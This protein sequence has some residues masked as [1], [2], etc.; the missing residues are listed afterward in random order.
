MG[1][2]G[3]RLCGLQRVGAGLYDLGMDDPL[4][5]LEQDDAR[6][7]AAKP[8][9]ASRLPSGLMA[10][11]VTCCII[12]C[13]LFFMAFTMPDTID[14]NRAFN[15][16]SGNGP[17]LLID[18]PRVPDARRNLLTLASVIVVVGAIFIGSS[19]IASRSKQ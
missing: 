12:G 9:R 3:V 11:G 19:A 17:H 16:E 7:P 8:A 4:G 15:I 10:V 13:I 5:F 6:K 14:V 18:D 1:Q 2:G